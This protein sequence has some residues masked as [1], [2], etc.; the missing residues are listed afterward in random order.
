METSACTRC[1]QTSSF[2]NVF[3][4]GAGSTISWNMEKI[5]EKSCQEAASENKKLDRN[6]K[7]E[8]QIMNAKR[9]QMGPKSNKEGTL[10]SRHTRL[11]RF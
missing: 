11:R 7:N 9:V 1:L 3:P 2:E 5:K 4:A 10:Y 6:G 8:E